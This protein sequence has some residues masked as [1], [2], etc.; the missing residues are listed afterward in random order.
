MSVQEDVQREIRSDITHAV[1]AFV[2][3]LFLQPV[4]RNIHPIYFS[5]FYVIKFLFPHPIIAL[6]LV[7]RHLIPPL[8][9]PDVLKC[10]SGF[11]REET[12]AH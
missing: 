8:N 7:H 11:R 9:C 2:D 10:V 3:V 6:S 1:V 5:F 12:Q 4:Q